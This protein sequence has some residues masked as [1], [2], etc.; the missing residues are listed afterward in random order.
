MRG[1]AGWQAVG[2]QVLLCGDVTRAVSHTY[3][4]LCEL[5]AVDAIHE[6]RLLRVDAA[7]T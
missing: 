7:P 4:S 6:P 5:A 2:G 1:G 3:V